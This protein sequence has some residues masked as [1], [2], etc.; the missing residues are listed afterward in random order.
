MNRGFQN[1][2]G[3][4]VPNNTPPFQ[5]QMPMGQRGPGPFNQPLPP[6]LPPMN[7]Q[8]FYTHNPYLQQGSMQQPIRQ[9]GNMAG[10]EKKGL[11]TKI[12]SKKQQRNM[13]Q[14]SPFSLPQ[15]SSRN[16]AAASTAATGAAATSGGFLQSVLNPDN[17]SS[18]LNNTQR[19]LAAAESFGPLVQ[20]YGSVVK[21]IPA[22]WKLFQGTKDNDSINS[23]SNNNQS[24]P[25]PSPN[26]KEEAKI[27]VHEKK[28]EPI[29]KAKHI[30]HRIPTERVK[31]MDSSSF[32]RKG[33]SKPKLFI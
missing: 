17:L 6:Q 29:R 18:M 9:Q 21:N 20:Q 28:A 15:S 19:V 5:Q 3:R 1:H 25:E 16:A 2:I 12:F 33:E 22:M 27:I 4:G 10:P 8:G 24:E 11:L 23:D 14:Q 31:Q 30:K 32:H 26:I 7:T 13:P